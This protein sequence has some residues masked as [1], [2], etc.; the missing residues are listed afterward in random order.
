[1]PTPESLEEAQSAADRARLPT[2]CRVRF[3]ASGAQYAE[4]DEA[5]GRMEGH[6]DGALDLLVEDGRVRVVRAEMAPVLR[7]TRDG[8]EREVKPQI[9]GESEARLLEKLA[10]DL[11]ELES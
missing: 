10:K 7:R 4:K 6:F 5:E 1:L 11:R 9:K 8:L 2:G 3:L